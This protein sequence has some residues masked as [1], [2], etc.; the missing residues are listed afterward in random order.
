MATAEYVLQTLTH[1]EHH[2]ELLTAATMPGEIVHAA[3]SYLAT[4]SKD[5]IENLQKID[6]G[7]GP[8][9]SEKRP[10]PIHGFG[11]IA[12]ISNVLSNHCRALKDAG[13]EPTPEI[14]ELDLYF[15]LAKQIGDNFVASGSR[16]R[17]ATSPSAGFRHLS[18]SDALAA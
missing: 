2:I 16:F 8:F 13:I 5:R 15:A 14:L 11:Y 18:H 12:R 6:G 9:D 1:V 4:W 3:N 7:W 17:T 10:E